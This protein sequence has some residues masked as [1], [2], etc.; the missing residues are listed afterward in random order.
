MLTPAQNA[1]PAPDVSQ[2]CTAVGGQT[3]YPPLASAQTAPSAPIVTTMEFSPAAWILR[4][5]SSAICSGLKL[6]KSSAKKIPASCWLQ[7]KQFVFMMR[8][9]RFSAMLMFATSA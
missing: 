5:S 9:R 2:T 3:P 4:C 7:M 6:M 1:S 8:S